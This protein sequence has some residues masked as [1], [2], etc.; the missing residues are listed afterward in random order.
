MVPPPMMGGMPPMFMGMPPYGMN[1]QQG[2]FPMM[3]NMPNA[4]NMPNMPNMP[5]N[6]QQPANE[7][8]GSR[9]N[10]PM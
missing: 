3:P 1:P 4:P 7:V 9:S 5:H 6:F 10:R 8:G 2:G